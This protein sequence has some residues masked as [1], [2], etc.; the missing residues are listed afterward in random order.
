MAAE[1]LKQEA[2]RKAEMVA[3][4]SQAQSEKVRVNQSIITLLIGMLKSC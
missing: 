4:E 3:N 2:I 1:Q